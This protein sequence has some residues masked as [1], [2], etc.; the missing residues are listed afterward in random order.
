MHVAK[1]MYFALAKSVKNIYG[2]MTVLIKL[3]VNYRQLKI[4]A[5]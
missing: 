2:K 1:C 4:S 3:K 5:L